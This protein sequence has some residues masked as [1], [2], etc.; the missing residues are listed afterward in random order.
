VTLLEH[1]DELSITS[2]AEITTRYAKAYV[3][4][5][6]TDKGRVLDEVVSVTGWSR[7][8]ARRRLVAAAKRP[9]GGGRQVAKRPRK[10][11]AR[12]YSYDTLKVLQKVWAAS[13]GQCGKYL[14]AS[15]RIQLDG[16]TSADGT[17]SG[18]KAQAPAPTVWGALQ[19]RDATELIDF[20]VHTIG[21]VR[22]AV[23]ADGDEVAHAQLD[24][25]EG[26]GVMLGSHT[27]TRRATSG[28]S[29]P[30]AANPLRLPNPLNFLT[31][32]TEMGTSRVR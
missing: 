5:G 1:E 28:R 29:A 10:P 19:A 25:P 30:I 17:T 16:M 15:M 27:P 20:L 32:T 31:S 24:W 21:F 7:D 26:G 18:Q 11:R 3:R 14:A 12:K 8:N 9:P 6:R 13:G 4:A 23:Y 2:R 22:T